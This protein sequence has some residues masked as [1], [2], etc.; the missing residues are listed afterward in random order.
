SDLTRYLLIGLMAVVLVTGIFLGVKIN[1]NVD[2][3]KAEVGFEPNTIYVPTQDKVIV[4]FHRHHGQ[5]R[6]I[7]GV[8]DELDLSAE[9]KIIEEGSTVKIFNGYNSFELD[10]DTGKLLKK[11]TSDFSPELKN[12]WVGWTKDETS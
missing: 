11:V 5:P 10:R 9:T 12:G 6:W 3:V 2:E 7:S 1:K 8:I 4:S